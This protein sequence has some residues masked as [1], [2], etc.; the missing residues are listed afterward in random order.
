VKRFVAAGIANLLTG[1]TRFITGAQARWIGCAPRGERRV[2]FGNHASHADFVLIWASLPPL[3]RRTTRPV[4]GADYWEKGAIR[5]YLIHEVLNGVTIDR[6][7]V[8]ATSDPVGKMAEAL[9]FGDSLIVFPEGTRNTTEEPLLPFKS[10]IFHLARRCPDVD[11]IPVWMEN[12]G[13]VLPKGE[14]IPVPMLCSIN[15]GEPIRLAADEGKAEFLQRTREA[16]LALA[17]SVRPA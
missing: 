17:A 7:R 2:Y 11:F 9:A 4:A 5:R 16:L 1:F 15:F 8:N 13:R 12:Q 6:E 14:T 3:L 10:G